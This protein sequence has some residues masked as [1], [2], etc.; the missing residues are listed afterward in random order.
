MT[1][2]PFTNI[3]LKFLA[4]FIAILVW[5]HVATEK[6]YIFELTLP[7]KE[8]SVRD[9][10]VLA[11]P[12]PDSLTVTVSSTGKQL[13]RKRWRREG[14][15]LNVTH[16]G[17]GRH[18][19]ELSAMNTSMIWGHADVALVEVLSPEV[20]QI[21]LDAAT[22]S[23]VP[24]VLDFK[25]QPD[26]GLAFNGPLEIK[27]A[28]VILIGPRRRI[29]SVESIQ[30]EP[31]SF[32]G[33]RGHVAMRAALEMPAGFGFEIQPDSV[34]IIFDVVPVKSRILSGVPILVFNAPGRTIQLE[35]RVV[36]VQLEGPPN[37]IDTLT[38]TA[39][40]VSADYR[41]IDNN[42]WVQLKIDVP[43]QLRVVALSADSVHISN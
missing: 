12:L 36:D 4:L 21:E 39:V 41:A 32:A 9:T 22:R 23:Q 34:L 33:L 10:L 29:D 38:T 18:N 43:R 13:F 28:T 1:M 37:L 15:R 6:D 35:P 19:L 2:R 3:W 7:V 17:S 8:I 30:T 14:L 25:S 31:L 27:P 20:V 16:L 11:A 5:L 40:A 24:V 42:R 26:E